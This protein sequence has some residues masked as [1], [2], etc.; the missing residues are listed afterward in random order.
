MKVN[1]F[2]IFGLYF[3]AILASFLAFWPPTEAPS[4]RISYQP[5]NKI[6][7]SLKH[8]FYFYPYNLQITG[9]ERQFNENKNKLCQIKLFTQG[10][11]YKFLGLIPT[12]FHFI[13]SPNCNL[14]L[15]GT[16]KLGRDYFS[17]LLHG[18]RPSLFTGILGILIAFPL[19]IIYGTIAGYKEEAAGEIMMRFIEIILSLPTLY[20]LIILAAILPAS[21]SNEQRLFLITIILSFIGWAGL[22]RVVRGQVLSIKKREFIQAAQILG[23]PEWKIIIREIIPQLSTYLIIAITLSFPGYVLGE[24]TLSFLGLGINQPEASLGNLLA[25]GREL[26]NL[27]L[28]PWMAIGPTLILILL[29]WCCNSLGDQLRDIF[30]PKANV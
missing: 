20:L 9:F 12:N 23:M 8:G 15:L 25:E 16:D 27:F 21:L 4:Q 24:T 7:F 3:V 18:L 13:G 5:P 29:T 30:D 14:H 19:G 17:R 22:A 28:R 26:S 11:A 2:I 6:N 1:L 10:Y